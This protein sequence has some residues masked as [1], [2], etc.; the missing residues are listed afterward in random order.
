MI[1]QDARGFC[2]FL[3]LTYALFCGCGLW[4]APIV[5]YSNTIGTASAVVTEDSVMIWLPLDSLQIETEDPY[6]CL[7]YFEMDFRRWD[8]AL[9][10]RK[11]EQTHFGVWARSQNLRLRSTG[12]SYSEHS[13]EGIDVR[14]DNGVTITMR[15]SWLE[16]FCVHRP[17][18]L[19]FSAQ[20][21]RR[22]EIRVDYST[23]RN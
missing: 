21:I 13:D 16:R 2:V 9:W 10:Y 3:A 4:S 22:G 7:V 1:V 12:P 19:N 15:S 11:G 23:G 14:R 6:F 8:I 5:S 18:K 20:G 17:K